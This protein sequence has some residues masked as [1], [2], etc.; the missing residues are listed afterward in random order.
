MSLGVSQLIRLDK[1][2]LEALIEL[3]Y[4]RIERP[5]IGV[6]GLDLCVEL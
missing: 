1:L 6:S 3:A 2:V 4:E 5:Q